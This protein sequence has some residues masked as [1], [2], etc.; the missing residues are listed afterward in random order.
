M[1]FELGPQQEGRK[2]VAY[3][4]AEGD[5]RFPAYG[6]TELEEGAENE[7]KG[8][9]AL[10]GDVYYDLDWYPHAPENKAVFYPGDTLTITF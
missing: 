7:A 4:D 5:L 2:P 1:K 3:L 8:F 6:N 9:S 10:D